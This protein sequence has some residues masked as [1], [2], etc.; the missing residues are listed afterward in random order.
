MPAFFMFLMVLLNFKVLKRYIQKYVTWKLFLGV[1]L[2]TM[3][4]VRFASNEVKS[5]ELMA[6]SYTNVFDW[7]KIIQLKFFGERGVVWLAVVEAIIE[8]KA[9][10]PL[11]EPLN[12]SYTGKGIEK[13]AEIPA[14]NLFLELMRSYGV[15]LG[16]WISIVYMAIVVKFGKLSIVASKLNSNY[17]ILVVS[18]FSVMLLPALVNQYTLHP[19][20]SF[21]LL[22]LAGALILNQ[23]SDMN[24]NPIATN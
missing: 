16:L 10:Y 11:Y 20:F 3:V 8:N 21:M 19:N 17:Y 14:H 9:W 7:F 13:E 1:F 5:Y 4:G 18:V 6:L 23:N 2:F 12:Y 22:G 15:L 24:S